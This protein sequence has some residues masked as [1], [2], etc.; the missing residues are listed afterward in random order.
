MLCISKWQDYIALEWHQTFFTST[1][2]LD[3]HDKVTFYCTVDIFESAEA[4]D[5]VLPY[6]MH[7]LSEEEIDGLPPGGGLF[8]K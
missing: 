1:L 7:R 4:S 5:I 6:I 8:A 3:K 2:D